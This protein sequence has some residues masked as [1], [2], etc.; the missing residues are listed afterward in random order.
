MR[1]VA[2]LFCVAFLSTGTVYAFP[3]DTIL[4]RGQENGTL[5]SSQD[6]ECAGIEG[7]QDMYGLG[8]R[9]AVYL[10]SAACFIGGQY[11]QKRVEDLG[12]TTFLF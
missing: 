5:S 8:I 4:Q 12:N 9:L 10:Q 11:T 6:L 2:V 1:I 3:V 7:G